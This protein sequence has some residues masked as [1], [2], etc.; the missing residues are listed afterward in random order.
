MTMII[1]LFYKRSQPSSNPLAGICED[2]KNA[3]EIIFEVIFPSQYWGYDDSSSLYLR[4]G[5]PELGRWNHNIG[6]FTL[7][8][9]VYH[10]KV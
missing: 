3:V 2:N 6:K 1:L 4:F 8:R 9:L 5:H 10:Q 7:L